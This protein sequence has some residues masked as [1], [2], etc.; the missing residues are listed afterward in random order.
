MSDNKEI[1]LADIGEK[2]DN[3]I[4]LNRATYIA[5]GAILAKLTHPDKDIGE[6]VTSSNGDTPIDI[7]LEQI[8]KIS[9]A[10]DNLD[11]IEHPQPRRR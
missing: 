6:T 9:E 11:F 10:K 5:L 8:H 3:L 7:A 4:D 1:T 2:L